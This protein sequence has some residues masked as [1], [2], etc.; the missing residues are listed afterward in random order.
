MEA[1][2]QAESTRLRQL[3]QP[4]WAGSEPAFNPEQYQLVQAKIMAAHARDSVEPEAAQLYVI[5]STMYG[6]WPMHSIMLHTAHVVLTKLNSCSSISRQAACSTAYA[7][8]RHWS[9][10]SAGDFSVVMCRYL[11]SLLPVVLLFNVASILFSGLARL[12]QTFCGPAKSLK[13]HVPAVDMRKVQE[14]VSHINQCRQKAR[15]EA[16]QQQQAAGHS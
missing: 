3:R 16:R 13:A 11:W 2:R 10:A 8:N 12:L 5:L 7:R 14:H 9:T 1:W 6:P 15:M 4:A